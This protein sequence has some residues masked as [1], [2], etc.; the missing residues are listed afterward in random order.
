[1]NPTRQEGVRTLRVFKTNDSFQA[2]FF[3]GRN[4]KLIL[5]VVVVAD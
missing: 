5:E 3:A 2:V 1:M 4:L